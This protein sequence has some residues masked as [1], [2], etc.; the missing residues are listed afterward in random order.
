ML[1]NN[2]HLTSQEIAEE[3]GIHHTTVGGHIKYLG[4]VLKCLGSLSPDKLTKNNLSDRVKMCSSHLIRYNVESFLD[5]RITGEEKWILYE[6]I[7]RKILLQ[8]RNIISNSSKTKY[9]STKSTTL[10][11]VG[12][13]RS[14]VL[15]VAEI[16]KTINADLYCNQI[17][18]NYQSKKVS[19]SV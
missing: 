10:F 7:K 3:F 5:K 17:E 1:E 6:N 4:F 9:T 12:H 15:R 14:S 19:L 8:T 11:V 13:E 18:C 16:G 2:L